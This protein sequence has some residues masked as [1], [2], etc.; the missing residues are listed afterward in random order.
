MTTTFPTPGPLDNFANPNSGG[1]DTL[2]SVPHDAQHANANDAIEAL[3]AKVGLDGS[4]VTTAIDYILNHLAP[5][6]TVAFPSDISPAQLTADQDNYNPSGLQT[7]TVLRLT[8]NASRNVTGLTAPTV[9][10]GNVKCIINVG[11][12]NAI[13][14]KNASGSSSA[15]NRFNL[16]ADITLNPSQGLILW[17][18]STSSQWRPLASVSTGGGGAIATDTFWAAKGDIAAATANDAASVVPVGANNR[19]LVADSTAGTGVAWKPDDDT[20]HGASLSQDLHHPRAHTSADHTDVVRYLYLTCEG[21]NAVGPAA[22]SSSGADPNELRFIGM[23]SATTERI[24]IAP[25][26]VPDDWVSGMSAIVTWLAVGPGGGAETVRWSIDY[27]YFDD[28]TSGV[29]AGTNVTWTGISRTRAANDIQAESPQAIA[30]GAVAGK[31]LRITL[32]RIGADAADTLTGD[33]GVVSLRLDYT[34]AD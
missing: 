21:M 31:L 4:G 32:K 28:N 34:A 6:A 17:Y 14:L 25:F 33:A 19:I 24:R 23:D 9:P 2:A 16:G 26:R 8:S 15:A 11:A 29:A 5:T 22:F 7:S 10:D 20:I 18:D 13:V 27:A 12:T 1:G 30:T 3:E